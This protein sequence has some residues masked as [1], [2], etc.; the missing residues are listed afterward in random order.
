MQPRLLVDGR[1]LNDHHAGVRDFWI[2]VLAAWARLGGDA[3]IG[4]SPEMTPPAELIAAGCAAVPLSGHPRNPWHQWRNAR[5]VAATGSGATLSPLYLTLTGTP[6]NLATIFDLTGRRHPRGPRSRLLWELAVAWTVRRSSAVI[7][8]THAVAGELQKSFSAL[9]NRVHVV[10]A[11]APVAVR[12]DSAVL[13]RYALDPPYAIAI[14]SHRPHKR[15]QELAHTWIMLGGDL[16]LVI[17][18]QGTE[19]LSAPPSV[20]GL[21][22]VADCDLRSLLAGAACLISASLAEGFGLPVLAAMAAGVPIVASREAALEEVAGSAA[23]WL[24]RDD[25]RGLVH[26]AGWVSREP[27]TA[28]SRVAAGRERAR[29]LSASRSAAQLAR[30]LEA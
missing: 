15:L 2:P 28:R 1:V 5:E 27:Q 17:A 21:G 20:R 29:E 25:L 13:G 4:H 14:A 23:Q 3:L 22:F 11:V 10:S 24:E 7:C 6:R 26:A 16:P 12:A 8:A 30:A 18:G 9:R 19:T